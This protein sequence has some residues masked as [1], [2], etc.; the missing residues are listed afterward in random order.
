MLCRFMYTACQFINGT[1]VFHAK[2][3]EFC[4]IFDPIC[5]L[6]KNSYGNNCPHSRIL[7]TW[8]LIFCSSYV[9]IINTVLLLVDT[10]GAMYSDVRLYVESGRSSLYF[11]KLGWC[12]VNC[13]FSTWSCRL[14]SWSMIFVFVF[15]FVWI[16]YLNMT[17]WSVG[18]FQTEYQPDKLT[19]TKLYYSSPMLV[20]FYDLWV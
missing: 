6:G 13:L 18:R 11:Y 3:L 17:T 19:E 20:G 2:S 7:N 14:L 1:S 4:A 10:S 5:I 16:I 12:R 15:G 8:R 9:S